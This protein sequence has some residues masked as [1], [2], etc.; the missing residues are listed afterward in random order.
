MGTLTRQTALDPAVTPDAVSWAVFYIVILYGIPSR[1]VIPAL[2]SAGAPSMVVGLMSLLIW[3]MFQLRRVTSDI[4]LEPRP[5][6]RGLTAFLV[7]VFIA[8]VF[9]MVR[10]ISSDEVSPADVALLAVLSWSGTL[11]IVNDGVSS[12]ERLKTLTSRLAWA[13]GLLGLLGLVQFVTGDVLVDRISIPGLRPAEFD[14]EQRAGFIR[15]SGTASHPIE[16]GII[17]AMVVPFALHTAFH[18]RGRNLILRWI[19]ALTLGIS[20]ALTFSR[21]AYVGVVVALA[22][23]LFGWPARRRLTFTAGVALLCL[24]LFAAVPRLFGTITSLFRNVGNDPSITSRTDS[25]DLATEFFLRYPLFGRGLGTFLPK[26]RIFDNQYLLLLVSVG[27]VGTVA[28]LTLFCSGIYSA[29]RAAKKG[30]DPEIR[31]LGFSMAASIAAGATSLATFDAFA[32]PMTMG[33]L[34]LVLGM[35]GALYR[36]MNTA[37]VPPRRLIQ[38]NSERPGIRRS[39]GRARRNLTVRE[40]VG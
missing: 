11:L 12:I 13:G 15:P 38:A 32:F 3:G 16:F 33:T 10:P 24:G 20:M 5:V 26:L 7:C 29:L 19:P 18:S 36:L 37:S 22:I 14:L 9:A 23:L 39:I 1:N 40:N 27:L 28:A 8:Y 25:Y 31:D 6:R 4:S 34:F 21:S 30:G 17:L 35:A 2:G